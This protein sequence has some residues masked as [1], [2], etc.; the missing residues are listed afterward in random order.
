MTPPALRVAILDDYQG[1]ALSMADWQGRLPD[2]EV[3][4]FAD[5]VTHEAELATLLHRFEVVVAMRERTPIRAT[6]I[7]RLPNLKLLVTTGMRNPAI[8]V[9]AA[10]AAGVMVCGTRGQTSDTGELTWGLILA[11]ARRIVEEDAAVRA[12][13]WQ[14]S[15]GVGLHGRTLGLVGLGNIGAQVGAVG[16]AFGMRIIAWSAN[17]TADRAAE[18]GA[19]L[20]DRDALF[21][22]A[23]VVSLHVVLGDRYRGLV[24]APELRAMKRTAFLINT[25][26]GPL[27]DEGALLQALHEGWIGG[28]GLDVYDR[29]PLPLDHP[30]RTA[31]RTVLV[32]H[33]GFVTTDNY[34]I[35]Y[36][37]ALDDVAAF[38]LGVPVRLVT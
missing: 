12:G 31:P 1:V 18:R 37:D 8:D 32:P 9:A 27:V 11:L 30:L 2:V 25:S 15:V 10:R 20:V 21:A 35:L 23:D 7:E 3:V 26:R 19:E 28:A 34:Q 36:G 17:L 16:L 5:H 24:G 29:E 22:E 14:Q 33:M 13:A 4:A 6:L 38:R